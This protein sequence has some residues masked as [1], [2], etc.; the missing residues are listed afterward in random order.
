MQQNY[1]N[2]P[3][4]VPHCKNQTQTRKVHLVTTPPGASSLISLLKTMRWG[5]EHPSACT[6][7]LKGRWEKHSLTLDAEQYMLLFPVRM[8]L[9]ATT[10]L[11]AGVATDSQQTERAKTTHKGLQAQKGLCQAMA[12]INSPTGKRGLRQGEDATMTTKVALSML[13]T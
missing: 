4:I 10:N 5:L 12:S 13:N 2:I 6:D 9:C 8:Y 3:T 7:S 11:S 1:A